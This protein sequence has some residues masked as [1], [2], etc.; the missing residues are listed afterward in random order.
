MYFAGWFMCSQVAVNCYILLHKLH[1]N[2]KD[3]VCTRYG[4]ENMRICMS[5][6][7]ACL[8]WHFSA[9]QIGCQQLCFCLVSQPSQNQYS[10]SEWSIRGDKLSLP[11][12][13][14]QYWR[15]LRGEVRINT[16]KFTDN[17]KIYGTRWKL[18]IYIVLHRP[19]ICDLFEDQTILN[20]YRRVS[21]LDSCQLDSWIYCRLLTDCY[22]TSVLQLLKTQTS[23]WPW[24]RISFFRLHYLREIS[25]A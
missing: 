16:V 23:W 21:V 20:G 11:V 5:H 2:L 8:L 25:S 7:N 6:Y 19:S 10:L 13:G 12:A 14:S 24:L 4:D 18:C 15:S 9:I 1:Y 3:D 17:T 22:L